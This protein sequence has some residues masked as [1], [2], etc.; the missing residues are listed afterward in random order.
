MC[1]CFKNK[2]SKCFSLVPQFYSRLN[3]KI[4]KKIPKINKSR[5]LDE[6][7][8]EPLCVVNFLK[9]FFC[10]EKKVSKC[11]KNYDVTLKIVRPKLYNN[12]EEEKQLEVLLKIIFGY[13]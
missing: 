3:Y 4:R 11:G 7:S 6:F 12:M 9:Q 8:K 13:P 2:H 5:L 1:I 10:F